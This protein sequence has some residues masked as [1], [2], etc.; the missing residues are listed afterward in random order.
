MK[1][2]GFHEDS[3]L[4][5]FKTT[6]PNVPDFSPSFDPHSEFPDIQ[7]M[8]YNYTNAV[9]TLDRLFHDTSNNSP[10]TGFDFI[11]EFIRAANCFDTNHLHVVHVILDRLN[12]RLQSPADAKP[13]QRVA[14]Y[15][16]KRSGLRWRGGEGLTVRERYV[17]N[18]WKWVG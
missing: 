8:S 17:C 6:F 2:L 5:L 7:T 15:F 9:A 10:P 11:E 18:Y 1:D 13:L 16:K 14:F 3:N 12:Q 4:P